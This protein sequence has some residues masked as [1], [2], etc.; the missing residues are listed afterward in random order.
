[1]RTSC[2]ERCSLSLND[3]LQQTRKAKVCPFEIVVSYKSQK[4]KRRRRISQMEKKKKKNLSESGH[5]SD[6]K[7]RI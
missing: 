2:L 6:V 5:A 7:K 4:K 3:D 1:M